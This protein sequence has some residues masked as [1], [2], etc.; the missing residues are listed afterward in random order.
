MKY[1]TQLLTA[2]ICLALTFTGCTDQGERVL[3]ANSSL[4]FYN[5]SQLLRQDLER[6]N[7]GVA[8]K[9]AFILVNTPVPV[10]PDTL[11]LPERQYIPH[12]AVSMSGQ[13]FYPML[14]VQPIPVPWCSYMRVVPGTQE[15]TFLQPD[16]TAAVK[17]TITAGQDV[18]QTVFLTDSLGIYRTIV[19]NDEHTVYDKGFSLR[20]IQATPDTGLL[21]VR[22]NRTWLGEN[23]GYGTASGFYQLPMAD[24]L[25]S[26]LYTVQVTPAGD[27]TNV[28]KQYLLKA[29]RMQS[30]T[31]IINGYLNYHEETN[32]ASPDFRL[33][34]IRNK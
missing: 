2:M 8:V 12:F 32:Y 19:T 29:G 6:K 1:F 15:L 11:R 21:R 23:W 3:P 10:K 20:I 30:Y 34:F 25:Q 14:N 18:S 13:Q 24:S 17:T 26:A 5:A 33:S 16:T 4:A 27:T 22:V 28:L 31:L 7:P 9:P